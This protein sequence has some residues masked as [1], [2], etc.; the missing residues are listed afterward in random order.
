VT[1][2]WL[3]LA[4]AG[5]FAPSR[6]ASA[7]RS[8]RRIRRQADAQTAHTVHAARLARGAA[9]PARR[10]AL[11]ALTTLGVVG[12]CVAVGGLARGGVAAVVLVPVAI[13]GVRRLTMR[14]HDQPPDHELDWLP[15]LIDLVAAGLLA[16]LPFDTALRSAAPSRLPWLGSRL[17]QVAGMLR[18]G[19]QPRE[20]WRLLAG[21]AQLR[22]LTV[23]AIR[24]AHS[25][26]R[27]AENLRALAGELRA[28]A[29]SVALA[30]AQ[31]I[32]VWVMVPLGLCFLP[33]FVCLGVI[34]VV[35]GIAATLTRTAP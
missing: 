32:G 24:S 27:L 16:G 28:E 5:W 21:Q 3:A 26:I 15:L 14:E 13:A 10:S 7:P 31:R 18:L 34:P 22:P 1:I 33:A 4:A 11:I 9:G 8:H 6:P 25:G 17:A 29:R 2:A 30:R 20:A 35:I 19:A 12:A 23:V